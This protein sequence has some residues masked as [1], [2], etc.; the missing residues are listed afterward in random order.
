MTSPR[1]R[2]LYI[3]LQALSKNNTHGECEIATIKEKT[4]DR[5]IHTDSVNF[6]KTQPQMCTH[7]E[8]ET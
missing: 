5:S 6:I 8:W 3:Q 4:H 1:Y 7:G 2:S